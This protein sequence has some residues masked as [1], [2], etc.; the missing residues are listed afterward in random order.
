MKKV[1]FGCFSMAILAASCKKSKENPSEPDKY[2]S[3]TTNSEWIYDVIT[4]P[5]TAGA[6]TVADTVKVTP[7]DTTVN[8][9]VYRIFRHNSGASDYYNISGS[10]Y[11]RYQNLAQAG[12]DLAIE[13]LY[14]KDAAATGANWSQTIP[15][16]VPGLGTLPVTFKNTIIEKGS[17]KTVLGTNYTDVIAV[18]TDI[19]VTGLPP[20]TI[21]TDIKSYYARKVGLIQGDYKVNISLIAVDVNTQTLLRKA[22]IK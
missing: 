13:D 18:R 7:T 12:L 21:V 1:L 10:D 2:M 6:S 4:N 9:R 5:G 22:D 17:S 11:Y 15:F 20:G 16:D 3:I 14:L 8:G 19:S